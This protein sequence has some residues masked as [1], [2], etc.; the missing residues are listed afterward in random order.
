MDI[1]YTVCLA[2][3]LYGILIQGCRHNGNPRHGLAAHLPGEEKKERVKEGRFEGGALW[4][5]DSHFASLVTRALLRLFCCFLCTLISL[6][7]EL[8]INL[9]NARP[10]FNLNYY[11][12]ATFYELE[13]RQP[14][15]LR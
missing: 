1:N 13:T 6:L 14:V 9:H 3:S 10:F 12:A 5:G 15:R 11:P 2:V 7:S 4:R 8:T